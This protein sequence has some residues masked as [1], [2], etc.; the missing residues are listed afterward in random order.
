MNRDELPGIARN[1]FYKIVIN[2]EDHYTIVP[3]DSEVPVGWQDTGQSGTRE[4]CLAY[5]EEAR[6]ETTSPGYGRRNN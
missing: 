1:T 6:P 4:A 5:I 3:T 2:H